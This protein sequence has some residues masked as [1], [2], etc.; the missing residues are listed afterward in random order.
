[1]KMVYGEWLYVI[2]YTP[3]KKI[4]E[5]MYISL[6]SNDEQ[7]IDKLAANISLQMNA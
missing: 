1:M 5:T 7:E 4:V 2:T 3:K 6:Q